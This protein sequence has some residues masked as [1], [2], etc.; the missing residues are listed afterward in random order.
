MDGEDV[1]AFEGLQKPSLGGFERKEFDWVWACAQHDRDPFDLG[2]RQSF[3]SRDISEVGS[4]RF[5][6]VGKIKCQER[7][8]AQH[9]LVGSE[10][11]YPLR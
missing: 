11:F 7:P 4:V 10:G 2:Q 3:L 1:M 5:V 6:A 8:L 9:W